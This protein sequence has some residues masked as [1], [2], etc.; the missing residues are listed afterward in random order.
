MFLIV[1]TELNTPAI[2]TQRALDC[3]A[4]NR[5]HFLEKKSRKFCVNICLFLTKFCYTKSI[6]VQSLET[7][8]RVCGRSVTDSPYAVGRL[9]LYPC[10]F[11]HAG[12]ERGITC[13]QVPRPACVGE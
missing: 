7:A 12:R 13:L 1:T 11:P 6:L 4:L 3:V 2:E 8:I 5:C 10:P 9:P